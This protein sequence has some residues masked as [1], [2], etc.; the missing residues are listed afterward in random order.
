MREE[1][2][3]VIAFLKEDDE[4]YNLGTV[5]RRLTEAMN[6]SELKA[7]EI[8]SAINYTMKALDELHFL[9]KV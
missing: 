2:C 3:Y 1:S 9:M 5:G 8:S 6:E 7:D 4:G